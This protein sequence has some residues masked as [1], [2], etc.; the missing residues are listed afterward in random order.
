MLIAEPV[1]ITAEPLRSM[2]LR[3]AG[4]VRAQRSAAWSRK[5]RAIAIWFVLAIVSWH[6]ALGISIDQGPVSLRDP[7]HAALVTRLQARRA[8]RPQQPLHLFVGSS[9][10]AVGFDAEEASKTGQ[11][12][13]FNFGVPGS[14][15]F[16]QEAILER[17]F[18]DG[19]IPER[20]YLELLHPFFNQAGVR[21]LDHSLLDGA[22]LN[23][24]EASDLLGYGTRSTGPLRRYAIGRTVPTLR[25]QAEFRDAIGLDVERASNK[26]PVE[27]IDAFGFRRRQFPATER[28]Q[29]TA[30]AHKQYDPFFQRFALAEGPWARMRNSVLRAKSRGTRVIVVVSPEASA[31]RSLYSPACREGVANL[32]NRVRTELEVDV[33]DARDWV[34]DEHFYDDHHLQSTGARIF[35]HRLLQ[36]AP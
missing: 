36:S 10:V 13:Y 24:H 11:A 9:R 21:S 8:E 28:P 14:G 2:P 22:R 26:P 34:G 15:P 6:L 7:E 29:L 16:L 23:A 5:H 25:H 33:I 30:L 32:L 17:L 4:K 12:L 18:A 31:F 1:P 20:L 27:V 3:V 35:T 19:I